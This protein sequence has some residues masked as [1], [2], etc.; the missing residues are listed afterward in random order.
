MSRGKKLRTKLVFQPEFRFFIGIVGD[1]AMEEELKKEAEE[2]KDICRV[3]LVE[4]YEGLVHKVKPLSHLLSE[5]YHGLLSN[6]TFAVRSYQGL[7]KK[8]IKPLSLLE[9]YQK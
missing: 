3:S 9:S 1:E 8:E 2:F 5:S 4:S 7:V 6:F